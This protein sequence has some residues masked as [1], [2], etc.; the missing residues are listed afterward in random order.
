MG[1]QTNVPSNDNS[2][3]PDGKESTD[4]TTISTPHDT[5]ALDTIVIADKFFRVV[6]ELV[7]FSVKDG[8]EMTFVSEKPFSLTCYTVI[9]R[10]LYGGFS[11]WTVTDYGSTYKSVRSFSNDV[12]HFEQLTDTTFKVQVFPMPEEEEFACLQIRLDSSPTLSE[13][14]FVQIVRND[15]Q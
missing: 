9:P 5:T 3:Q 11:A 15:I 8:L 12:S 1:I 13:Q 4:T 10:G 7:F 6:P 2:G 14:G